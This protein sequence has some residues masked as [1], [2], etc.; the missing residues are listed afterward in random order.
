MAAVTDR[1]P[2]GLPGL[3]RSPWLRPFTDPVALEDCLQWVNPLWS[4]GEIRAR[5]EAVIDETADT[6]TFVLTPNRH[7]P[8]HRAGQHVVL[9]LEV[10]GVRQQRCFTLSSSPAASGRR[11]AITVKRAGR[12][13]GW[14]HERL[15][16]GEVL[17]LSAP[18]GDFQLPETPPPQILMLSAGSGITP[19]MAMLRELQVRGFA[20]DIVFLHSARDA[21][22]TIFGAE[23]RQ[24]A[25]RWPSLRLQLHETARGGRL[26]AAAIARA[27]PDYAA[28]D[29]FLCGPAGFMEP[30][31][32]VWNGQGLASRLRY[33]RFGAAPL[34]P[35]AD[36]AAATVHCARSERLFT[37]GVDTLLVEAEQA[38]LSPRYGC[39]IGICH[40][41]QCRKVSGTVEN[42]LTGEVSSDAG[43]MIQLCVSRARSDLVIEL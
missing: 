30:L 37:A 2:A 42:L 7:W 8:G 16:V 13:T 31:I 18:A 20:G 1:S 35:A 15:Q 24:L 38:G 21:A 29:T 26:D 5:V 27:V 34:A 11:L 41:C 25:A 23:L 12:V 28:R 6:K 33:E 17:T 19:V 43:E 10:D 3:L 14:M 4:L 39:R 22:A 32:A 36:G 40:T 9:Q